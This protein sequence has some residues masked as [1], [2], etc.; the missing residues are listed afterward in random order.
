MSFSAVKWAFKQ[1]VSPTEKLVLLF[2]ADHANE[3][4]QQCWP[5]LGTIAKEAG[6]S[7]RSV[8]RSVNRLV[9]L[10]LLDRADRF[11]NNRQTSNV[12]TVKIKPL[13]SSNILDLPHSNRAPLPQVR[14]DTESPSPV[15]QSHPRGCHR[16][17][18]N[19]S[20]LRTSHI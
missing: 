6:L 5:S 12:Y 4:T 10:G 1:A 19:H 11:S 15:T 3:K 20:I 9:E 16:V 2:I 13:V 18:Q 7:T 17:I 14:G 8:I